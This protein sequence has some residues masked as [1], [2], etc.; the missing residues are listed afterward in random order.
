MFWRGFLSGQSREVAATHASTAR[1]K[2]L[3]Q[4]P[5]SSFSESLD[6]VFIVV[7]PHMG[8]EKDGNKREC[9]DQDAGR[10]PGPRRSGAAGPVHGSV[11]GMIAWQLAAEP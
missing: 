2:I 8:T 9:P 10:L 11:E 5:L 3:P 1:K 6:F 7:G 4:N